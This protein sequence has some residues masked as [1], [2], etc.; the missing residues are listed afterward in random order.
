MRQ[1]MQKA[2]FIIDKICDFFDTPYFAL[3]VGVIELLF[4]YL[5]IDLVTIVVISLVTSFAFL[6]KKNL[7]S[8]LVIF[9]F[10]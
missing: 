5:G 3:V 7:N 1:L 6:F 9:L 10:M 2:N 8:I 4:Y